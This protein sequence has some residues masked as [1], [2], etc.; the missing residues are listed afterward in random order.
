MRIGVVGSGHV[1][2]TLAA[3]FA[4]AGHEV[5][6][7]SRTPND[8]DLVEWATKAGVTTAHP[9]EAIK[10]VDVVINATP[11]AASVAALEG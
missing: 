1:G 4:A 6:V 10:A 11:G 5:A 3:G 7:G 8:A 9:T 2:R